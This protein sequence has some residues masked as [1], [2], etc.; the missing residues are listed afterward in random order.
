MASTVR[1]VMYGSARQSLDNV[2][3]RQQRAEMV[4]NP[5]AGAEKGPENGEKGVGVCNSMGVLGIVGES[6]N[7]RG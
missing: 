5:V 6:G 2:H 4:R 3:T 7:G 1:T